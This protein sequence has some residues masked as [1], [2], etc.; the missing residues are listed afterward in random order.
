MKTS[1][2]ECFVEILL[3]FIAMIKQWNNN[4]R[5][6]NERAAKENGDSTLFMFHAKKGQLAFVFMIN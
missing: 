1:H 2:K 5:E 4:K 3:H 6:E